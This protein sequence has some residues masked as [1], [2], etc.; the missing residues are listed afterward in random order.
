LPLQRAGCQ[1]GS[2]EA[3]SAGGR[4]QRAGSSYSR[5]NT[6]ERVPFLAIPFHLGTSG[7]KGTHGRFCGCVRISC[8]TAKSLV[9]HWRS[10][11]SSCYGPKHETDMLSKSP[12]VDTAPCVLMCLPGQLARATRRQNHRSD[13]YRTVLGTTYRSD[14]N[15]R[16]NN[17]YCALRTEDRYGYAVNQTL[18]S[19]TLPCNSLVLQRC[20]C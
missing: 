9:Q 17:H 14:G 12:N 5:R 7:P 16:V 6:G 18:N 19:H 11:S 2:S 8:C 3:W 4:S 13:R 15:G 1:P 10:C 20:Y